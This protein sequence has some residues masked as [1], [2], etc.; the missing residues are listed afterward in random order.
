LSILRFCVLSCWVFLFQ[1]WTIAPF[2]PAIE[3]SERTRTQATGMLPAERINHEP[4]ATVQKLHDPV[5]L[6]GRADQPCAMAAPA[7]TR[8]RNTLSVSAASGLTVQAET[9]ETFTW[10]INEP[11]PLG[12]A[13]LVI[14][15]EGIVRFRLEGTFGENSGLGY[16]LTP[17]AAAPFR[18]KQ[19]L[20]QTR[21]IIPLH[22]EGAPTHGDVKVRPLLA[23]PLRVSAAIIGFNQC[24]EDPD[25][26]P[27]TF[28]MTVKPGL[29]EIIIA[30][31]FEISPPD[32]IISSPDGRRRLEVFGQRFHL[33]D[34]KS[35]ALLTD[36]AGDDPR[37]S[38]TGRFVVARQL[39]RL[40]AF[41][42]VDGKLIQEGTDLFPRS[43]D[44]DVAWDDYDSFTIAA[45]SG[46]GSNLIIIRSLL[47]E[48]SLILRFSGCLN[49]RLLRDVSL[50]IDLENN[51]AASRC[52]N[53]KIS[54]GSQQPQLVSLTIPSTQQNGDPSP[55]LKSASVSFSPPEQWEMI[56]SLRLTH[57][58]AYDSSLKEKLSAYI[59]SPLS[60]SPRVPE[61]PSGTREP[62]LAVS[63]SEEDVPERS[64]ILET[65]L[66]DFG[67]EL[68]WGAR[69][70]KLDPRVV[71]RGLDN[72]STR[73][74]FIDYPNLQI[75]KLPQSFITHCGELKLYGDGK[76]DI[77]ATGDVEISPRRIR[78]N[79]FQLTILAGS[80]MESGVQPG[81]N[82]VGGFAYLYDSR[83]PGQL[84]NL[85]TGLQAR[86]ASPCEN[87]ACEF[88]GQLFDDRFLVLWSQTGFRS[89]IYDVDQREVVWQAFGLPSIDI[90]QR[91]S[92][93]RDL[94]SLVK[95]DQDGYFQLFEL[96]LGAAAKID[97]WTGEVLHPTLLSGRVVDDEVVVWTPFGQFD[98]TFEGASHVGLRFPGRI[99]EYTLAQFRSIFFN[100]HLLERV[101]AG[102]QFQ[103][104][105]IVSFPPQIT[106]LPR[107]TGS[108]IAG[109]VEVVDDIAV[110]E[111]RIY[112]D[113][114]MTDAIKVP[115]GEKTIE[116]NAKRLPEARWVA[117]LARSAA[118]LYGQAVTFDAGPSASPR[119][120][121]RLISIGIDHYVNL[122]VK[123][124][125]RYAGRDAANFARAVRDKAGVE[126]ITEWVPADS[127]ATREMIIAKLSQTI[128]A[129]EPSDTIIIFI[130]GHGVQT[131]HKEY[132]L[133]TSATRLEDIENTALPWGDVSRILVE[134]HSRI[135]VFLD[136]CHSGAAG[137]D[138]FSSNDA[139]AAALLD[140]GAASILIFSASKGREV[141]KESDE[142]G[143]GGEFTRA[144]INAIND[145]KTDLNLNGVI[146]AS[147]LYAAVKQTV[148][149]STRGKQTPWFA[150]NDMIGDFVPF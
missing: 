119:R 82:L 1:P 58:S 88:D 133:A 102:E 53:A 42:A 21:V 2:I 90:V 127:E 27:V 130:A 52:N 46:L 29:P 18:I 126:I 66:S 38:P 45:P 68:N 71:F 69:V 141:S 59:S 73:L 150:R 56:E 121:V 4:I 107:F 139:S 79:N 106:A 116:F 92:L 111:L 142:Q 62:L 114:L 17:E 104:S 48:D 61:A 149:R 95:L 145:P 78:G 75:A 28:D 113:G 109:K 65:R 144:L 64:R 81:V 112:Q 30:D 100:D 51:F 6:I 97:S 24:G 47:N 137:T 11:P 60:T 128:A 83:R 36:A 34:P 86:T 93:S 49:G 31:R 57:V 44:V 37:F 138:Y 110:D 55:L 117:F 23:G 20:G 70:V 94:R 72:S 105:P 13:Y 80:C 108:S 9:L 8:L 63:R 124:Q 33:V 43:Q 103:Q 14:S 136:A 123:Y 87:F 147:E 77:I 99:G 74:Q 85:K 54:G 32:K 135:A 122:E 101:L 25:P 40:S 22:V 12:P 91:M 19:F 134:A 3:A 120:R 89:A 115:A 96:T 76:A 148:V 15:T 16:A 26:S 143:G 118:G 98:T 140:R 5:Q 7:L 132:Y 129:A 50:K 35:G 67:I 41:D 125:L 84:F 39:N 10:Q 146:E 131:E